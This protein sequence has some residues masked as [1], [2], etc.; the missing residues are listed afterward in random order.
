MAAEPRPANDSAPIR[1]SLFD[2]AVEAARRD[3]TPP[4]APPAPRA[5]RPPIDRVA[6]LLAAAI[7]ATPLLTWGGATMLTARA[8]DEGR[9]IA[10]RAAPVMAEQ[11]AAQQARALLQQAWRGAPL[12]TTLESLA[13]ALPP[14]AALLRAERN[15]AGMI[16]IEVAAPDP[17]RLLAALRRDPVLAGLRATAQA[18]AD[19]DGRMRVTLEQRP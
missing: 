7:V 10:R 5:P 14:D 11:A 8:Q 2:R 6:A 15:A 17:D 12:G 9:A 1:P 18:R 3:P 13:R 19:G 16:A 4:R